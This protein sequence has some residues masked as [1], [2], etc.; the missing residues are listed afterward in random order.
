M[1]DA[2]ASK[3]ELHLIVLWEKARVCEDRILAD[4]SRHVEVVAKVELSWPDD[5]TECYGRFYGAKLKEAAGKTS[6]CGAGPFLLVIVRDQKPRYG[7]R[8][9]SRGCELVNLRMFAMKSRYRSWTGGGHRVHTTNSPEETRRDIF[10][11]TGRSAAEWEHDVSPAWCEVLPGRDGWPSL[12][13]LFK[14]LGETMQYVVLRNSEM[15]PD[16]FDPSIHGDIDLL[17]RDVGE[18]AGI[19]GASRVFADP[20][21]VHFEV[22]V[23]GRPVRFDLRYVGDGYYDERWERRMLESGVVAGGVRRPSPEDAFFALVYHAV[24]QKREIA[25]DYEGKARV[26]ARA[27]G[28]GGE[29]FDDW[30]VMLDEFL[31][32]RGWTVTKPLDESVY[33]DGLLA[34]WRE[35]A[36][37]M[38]SLAPLGKIRPFRLSSRRVSPYLPVIL[39][40]VEFDGMPCVAKYSPVAPQ[41]IAAEWE[42]PRR[43][44]RRIPAACIKPLFWHVMSGGGAFVV[45]E[46]LDGQTLEERLSGGVPI[47]AAESARFSSDIAEIVSALEAEGIVHRDLR[48][49]NLMVTSEGRLKVIDFQFAVDRANRDELQYFAKRHRELLYPLGADFAV[50]PG[51]WNDRHSMVGCLKLLPPCAARDAAVKELSTGME[52]LTVRAKLPRADRRHMRRELWLMRLRRLRRRL[53]LRKDGKRFVDRFK[54]LSYVLRSWD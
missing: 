1:S 3:G 43:L 49:A 54:Y 32:D 42:F 48:P 7:W 4:I 21:R 16:A 34:N 10:L 39:F 2:A 46:R 28:I 37:E 27:A 44:W 47:S 45:L 19:L 5:A 17:V 30:F 24:F 41:A 14:C 52:K 6:V 20:K 29:S 22:R 18:C 8:E 33:L 25:S 31:S 36:D 40:E 9:T 23:A 11:L 13:V 15:L 12:K 53:M 26:L 50:S 38:M 35:L 51:V